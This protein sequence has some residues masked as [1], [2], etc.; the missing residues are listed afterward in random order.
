MGFSPLLPAHI[1][2]PD[3]MIAAVFFLDGGP[4]KFSQFAGGFI[5]GHNVIILAKKALLYNRL[6]WITGV[7]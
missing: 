1:D 7:C 5:D 2:R 4:A 3:E 6:L